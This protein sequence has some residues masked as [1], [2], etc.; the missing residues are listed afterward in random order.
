MLLDPRYKDKLLNTKLKN[1]AINL[2]KKNIV[3]N[4]EDKDKKNNE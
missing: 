1:E 2:L 4:E 3:C